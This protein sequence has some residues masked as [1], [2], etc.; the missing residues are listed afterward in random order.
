MTTPEP[1]SDGMLSGVMESVREMPRWLLVTVVVGGGVL[2]WYLIRATKS[3]DVPSESDTRDASADAVAAWRER[4]R[5][6]LT[7]RG[8]SYTEINSALRHYLDG[9]TMTPQ[10]I[11]IIGVA[12]RELG[13]PGLEDNDPSYSV[14]SPQTLPGPGAPH[15]SNLGDT[16]GGEGNYTGQYADST[17]QTY[18]Y[19]PSLG[20]GPTSTMRGLAVAY[21]GDESYAPLVLQTNPGIVASIYDRIPTGTIVRVP[22]S[23]RT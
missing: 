22:R 20:F 14:S 13:V 8:Y 9:G 10:D 18:W 21:Y 6:L 2:A 11:T 16:T 3:D 23:V 1:Q 17:E 19:V 7:S 5:Q 15:A 4:A 12:I